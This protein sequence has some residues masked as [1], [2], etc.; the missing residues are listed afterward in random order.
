V[1]EDELTKVE[2]TIEKL[3]ERKHLA[4]ENWSKWASTIEKILRENEEVQ[5]SGLIAV[6]SSLRIWA[7]KKYADE[8]AG[9]GLSLDGETLKR[10][11][12]SAEKI[13]SSLVAGRVLYGCVLIKDSKVALSSFSEGNATLIGV[14]TFK[15]LNYVKYL[16]KHLAQHDFSSIVTVGDRYVTVVVKQKTLQALLVIEKDKFKPAVDEWKAKMKGF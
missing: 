12:V 1:I 11:I 14:L 16:P 9:E 7:M 5:V 6:P 15:F 4:L 2:D 8:H 3:S 13:A 10:K